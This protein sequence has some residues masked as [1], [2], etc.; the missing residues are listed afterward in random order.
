MHVLIKLPFRRLMNS[1]IQ[2]DVSLRL[3]LVRLPDNQSFN[4]AFIGVSL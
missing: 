4:I 1:S 2:G 3:K